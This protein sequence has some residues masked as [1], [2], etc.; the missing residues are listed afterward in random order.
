MSIQHRMG[1]QLLK[2]VQKMNMMNNQPMFMQNIIHHQ[3]NQAIVRV[4]DWGILLKDRPIKPILL[5]CFNFFF[6]GRRNIWNELIFISQC[7]IS[8]QLQNKHHTL[9][10]IP[11]P[12]PHH[13]LQQ[14]HRSV[15]YWFLFK[16]QSR[17]FLSFKLF[18]LDY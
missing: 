12:R 15:F 4:V 13:K 16:S 10:K 6:F 7:K 3:R 11:W 2:I 9:L 5:V 17:R 1:D 14:Q 18:P 8:M